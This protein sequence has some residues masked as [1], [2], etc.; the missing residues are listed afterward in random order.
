MI[1]RTYKSEGIVLK[2]INYGEADKIFTIYSKHFGKINLLAKGIRRLT[3]KKRGNLEIFSK[4][5][6]IA[7]KGKNLDIINEVKLLDGRMALRNNL[8]K[9]GAAYQICEV[10]DKLTA[11][12]VEQKEAYDLLDSYL[13][14]VEISEEKT[15]PQEVKNFCLEL[16]RILGF[17]PKNK[18]V[19]SN[20]NI[21]SFI[22]NITEKELK[23]KNFFSK[24]F[25]NDLPF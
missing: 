24:V 21:F 15:C 12:E 1:G 22:E 13:K 11:E 14:T 20:F 16:V 3:S 8:V 23:V 4:V 17:L 2:S 25:L 9:I 5:F 7:A 10:L 6:F 19:A 18:P